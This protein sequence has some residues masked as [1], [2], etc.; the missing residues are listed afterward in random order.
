MRFLLLML[1]VMS[2]SAC[3]SKKSFQESFEDSRNFHLFGGPS[4]KGPE[5]QWERCL[6]YAKAGKTRKTLRHTR[7]LVETW[8][9]HPLAIKALRLRAGVYFADE[10]F[11]FAF[12]T[13]QALIDDYS[14]LFDYDE[15]LSQQLECA[16]SMETKKYSAMFGLSH[17]LQPLEAIP[18]YEQILINAPHIQDAPEI[19][20]TIGEIYMRKGQYLKAVREFTTLEQT[21]PES[22]F[23]EIAAWRKTE[24]LSSRAKQV[25]TNLQPL[26]AE[27]AALDLFLDT[28]PNSERIEEARTRK[29][30]VYNQLA[31]SRYEKGRFYETSLRNPEAALITYKS[32]IEQYPDS[33]WTAQAEERILE[34]SESNPTP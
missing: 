24:A 4:K 28:Y 19:L 17:Y 9:D 23:S 21:F 34:L 7:Y 33:E 30:G 12:D 15:V 25:P 27:L 29:G 26:L 22:P 1:C 13:Y 3:S 32:L 2:L 31:K 5:D 8:P 20:L 16:R 14:G 10:Q 6:E 11:N 18:L